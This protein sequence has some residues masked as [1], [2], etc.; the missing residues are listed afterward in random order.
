MVMF[1]II[2]NVISGAAYGVGICYMHC[3]V[4]FSFVKYIVP[5]HKEKP[6]GK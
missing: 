3:K 4:A 5:K 6:S 1:H 2:S